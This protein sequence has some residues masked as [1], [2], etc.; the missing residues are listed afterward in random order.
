MFEW[1]YSSATK[2]FLVTDYLGSARNVF[3]YDGSG[4]LLQHSAY[5]YNT[6]GKQDSIVRFGLGALILMNNEKELHEALGF[7][8]CHYVAKCRPVMYS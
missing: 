7:G 3:A 8:M 2:S 1:A 6:F 4:D 5:W